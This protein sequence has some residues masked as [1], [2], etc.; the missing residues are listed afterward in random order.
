M[1]YLRNYN[2]LITCIIHLYTHISSFKCYLSIVII[3]LGEGDVPAAK[4]EFEKHL[5][6]EL[7]ERIIIYRVDEYLRSN[8]I[9]LE[10]VDYDR[11]IDNEIGLS[12]SNG[13]I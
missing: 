11:Y 12:E 10:E 5:Q 8:E 7:I 4:Q 1:L 3:Y 9:A 13:R 6:Y 2:N